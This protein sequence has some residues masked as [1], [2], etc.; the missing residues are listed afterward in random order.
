MGSK[1]YQYPEYDKKYYSENKDNINMQVRE[2]NKKIRLLVL[3]YYSA[4]IPFCACC[5]EKEIKFLAIDHIEGGGNKHRKSVKSGSGSNFYRWL[6]RNDFP[7]GFQVLC[8]NCNLAK[9][10]YGECPHNLT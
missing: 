6:L 8:H 2:N 1:K 4:Q 9:G 5:G 3:Q 10:F 7:K